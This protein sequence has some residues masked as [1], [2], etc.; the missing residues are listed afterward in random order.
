MDLGE[1]M[2]NYENFTIALFCCQNDLNINN[3]KITSRSF[4]L[5]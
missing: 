4:K 1:N 5:V 2:P 3:T